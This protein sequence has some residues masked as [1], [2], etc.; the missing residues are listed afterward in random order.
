M[1]LH[2]RRCSGCSGC[3]WAV[4]E[5]AASTAGTAAAVAAVA[6][7]AAAARRART[8][9]AVSGSSSVGIARLAVDAR[10]LLDLRLSSRVGEPPPPELHPN[11]PR[12]M[13]FEQRRPAPA[14]PSR[15][16]CRPSERAPPP[17]LDAR[18]RPPTLVGERLRH[19][20]LSAG[21]TAADRS[22]PDDTADAAPPP[23]SDETLGCGGIESV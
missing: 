22:P 6:A 20:P 1:Q 12:R 19:G 9:A 7:A 16:P 23:S 10:C 2:P 14:A 15:E 18:P 5:R 13:S 21:R 4:A 3:S 11:E 8:V 17:S